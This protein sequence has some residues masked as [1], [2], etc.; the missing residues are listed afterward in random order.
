MRGFLAVPTLPTKLLEVSSSQLKFLMGSSRGTLR[1]S[2]GIFIRDL[3]GSLGVFYE[4]CV[5]SLLGGL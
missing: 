2:A 4:T 5:S 3:R 1:F